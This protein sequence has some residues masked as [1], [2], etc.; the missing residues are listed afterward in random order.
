MRK[1]FNNKEN[2]YDKRSFTFE[3]K[4]FPR[5]YNQDNLQQKS[6]IVLE[7]QDSLTTWII[8]LVRVIFFS[9]G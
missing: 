3:Q 5:L 8:A 1:A 2:H 9:I 6:F 4:S 7:Y